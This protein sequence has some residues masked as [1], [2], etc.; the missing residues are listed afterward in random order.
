MDKKTSMWQFASANDHPVK[1]A[2]LA[3]RWL[4]DALSVLLS[5]EDSLM[6]VATARDVDELVS[7]LPHLSPDIVII[8]ADRHLNKAVEQITR[9]KTKLPFC[10]LLDACGSDES[11]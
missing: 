11:K 3:P 10:N 8:D 1:I 2:I 7:Q 6:L 5:S 9:I 4:Q